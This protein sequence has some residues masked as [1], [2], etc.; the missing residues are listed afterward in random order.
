LE[1]G[2]EWI[3]RKEKLPYG[4][5]LGDSFLQYAYILYDLVENR[6]ALAQTK[7]KLPGTPNPVA[8]DDDYAHKL[9]D[10]YPDQGGPQLCNAAPTSSDED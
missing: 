9:Q 4:A 8:F 1:S 10:G 3:D 2:I 6:V 5:I 7:A